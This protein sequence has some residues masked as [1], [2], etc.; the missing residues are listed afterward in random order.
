VLVTAR[1][2]L[3]LATTVRPRRAPPRRALLTAARC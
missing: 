3:Y 2:I 1:E